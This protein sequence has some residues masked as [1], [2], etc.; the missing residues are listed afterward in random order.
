MKSYVNR[1]RFQIT[2][3]ARSFLQHSSSFYTLQQQRYTI[4]KKI[5]DAEPKLYQDLDDKFS[6]TWSSSLLNG[7]VRK[8][9]EVSIKNIL[10]NCNKKNI[11][12]S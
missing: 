7:V 1:Q 5:L 12:N 2:S 4:I 6:K 8:A 3:T 9:S 11:K 10:T